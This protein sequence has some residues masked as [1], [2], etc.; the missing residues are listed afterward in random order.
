M[1]ALPQ[2]HQVQMS[3]PLPSPTPS[4]MILYPDLGHLR[5]S[6]I[7]AVAQFNPTCNWPSTTLAAAHT[8]CGEIEPSAA[9]FSAEAH[10]A[11]SSEVAI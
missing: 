9:Y 6:I 2:I 3:P 11:G 5:Q 1:E 4:Q 8:A 7:T 10:G